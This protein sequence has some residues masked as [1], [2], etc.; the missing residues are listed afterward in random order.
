MLDNY[1]DDAFVVGGS[2]PWNRSVY[3]EVRGNLLS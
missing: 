2:K 1:L 3:K